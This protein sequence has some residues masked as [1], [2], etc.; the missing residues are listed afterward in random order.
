MPHNTS[1]KENLES[2]DPFADELVPAAERKQSPGSW[3]AGKQ[4]ILV[5]IGLGMA[6]AFGGMLVLPRLTSRPAASNPQ[7]G[8]SPGSAQSV[9][10]APVER[11][12][13]VSTLKA[14][15]T[16]AATDLL[17]VLPEATGIQIQQVLVDEGDSVVAGQVMA[18]LNNSVLQAQ[19]NQAQA[20]VVSAQ[21]VVRQRQAAVAQARA[22]LAEAQSNRGRY[23]GLARQGA[24]SRQEAESRITAAATAQEQ[25]RLAQ[26]DVSS[27]QAEVQSRR[28]QVQQLQTQLEQT[29]VRTPAAGVVAERVARVGDVTTGTQ[30]L[31]SIIRN[32]D[33][34]LQVKLPAT[35][36]VGIQPGALVQ[37]TSNSDTRIRL[38]GQV[39]EIAPLVDPQ[40]RQATVEV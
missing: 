38:Q 21:A 36:L 23:T 22:T 18:V 10:V 32:G 14:T 40:N 30:K 29:V 11:R 3:L 25:V 39:R 15:G 35:Q 13:V 16:V 5:G 31:F 6:I 37:V 27:A 7:V 2:I 4:G 19:L 17:P 33:L 1:S 20:Q 8:T 28:A 12:P 9:T 26:A 24:I 34:E